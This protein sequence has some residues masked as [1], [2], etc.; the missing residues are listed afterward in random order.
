MRAKILVIAPNEQI[1]KLYEE[2]KNDFPELLL[3]IRVSNLANAIA[4]V[5]NVEINYDVI[6][7][8]GETAQMISRV[9]SIPLIKIQFMAFDVLS[10]IRQA[11]SL[12]MPFAM[13]GYYP[14]IKHAIRIN[15]ML[16]Y[17]LDI[18]TIQ[19]DE[20]M[21]LKMREI[22]AKGYSIVVCGMGADHIARCIG[23]IPIVVTTSM[24]AVADSLNQTMIISRSVVR[25]KREI[26]FYKSILM[27]CEYRVL[28]YN[29][30]KELVFNSFDKDAAYPISICEKLLQHPSGTQIVEKI[31]NGMMYVIRQRQNDVNGEIYSVFSFLLKSMPYIP[32][33]NEIRVFSK[34][35][36]YDAFLMHFPQFS[37]NAGA[38]IGVDI[39]VV[40]KANS[41]VLLIGENGTGKEQIAALLFV[42]G[43]YAD[44]PYYVIDAE[45]IGDK[46]WNTLM[47]GDDSLLVES[48]YT[49]Y[50]KNLDRVSPARLNNLKTTIIDSGL[51]NRLKLIFSCTVIP[52]AKLPTQIRTF[53]NE[54]G[55]LSIQLKP[56]RQRSSIEIQTLIAMYINTIDDRYGKS[57]IGLSPE[58]EKMMLDYQ[59]PDN[60]QQLRRVISDLVINTD[61]SYIQAELVKK[62]LYDERSNLTSS[63]AL[64]SVLDINKRMSEIEK[65]VARAV[66][67]MTNGNQSQ[68]AAKL[69]ISRTTLW[70]LLS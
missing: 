21:E 58:A 39:Q 69:G 41:P 23:M 14:M 57:V 59:W 9:T 12:H 44:K 10:A 45:T 64:S 7:A 24:E 5:R 16:N 4:L 3:D 49:I 8:R 34:D 18:F 11:E 37:G 13:I 19:D 26:E 48:G 20:D 60:L 6:I 56:L 47:Y 2:A 62:V 29:S 42:N 66:L 43:S 54:L 1:K 65:D 55:A 52:G 61:T 32:Q 15:E 31:H 50:I 53:H 51:E 67:L 35:D 25:S 27:E 33:R 30:H 46:G 68:A 63:F 70:R 22:K 17:D 38:E 28:V 40:A 36:V